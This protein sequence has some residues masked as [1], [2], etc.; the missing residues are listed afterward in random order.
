MPPTEEGPRL[1]AK[2]LR[3]RIT[4]PKSQS[5]YLSDA[6]RIAKE[7]PGY[8]V[9]GSG[10]NVT[11]AVDVPLPLEDVQLWE[12][13]RQLAKIVQ[14]WKRSE[15]VI[16]GGPFDSLL[17]LEQAVSAVR[18]C[19][20]ARE[21]SALGDMFCLG[22]EAPDDDPTCF[23]CRLLEGVSRTGSYYYE[24]LGWHQFGRLSEDLSSFSVDKKEIVRVCK[25]RTGDG[26]CTSCPAFSWRRVEDEINELPDMIRLGDD[27]PYEVKYSEIDATQPLGIRPRAQSSRW[28]TAIGQNGGGGEG[29]EGELVRNVPSVR[30]S[31]IAAQ[32]S[33]MEEIKNVVQLPLT[34]PDYFE[35]IGVEP[36]R[37][38]LLYGPPG[39]GK[40]LIGQAVATES[41]AHLEII[42][43]PE[44]VS[45]WVG[46]SA[47]NLRGIFER[48][49][50][51]EPS[52]ILVD[53]IDA[54]APKRDVASHQHDVQ[55]VS[56]LLVLLDGLEVRGRVVVIGAT[57]RIDSVDPAVRR[58]GRFDYH[59]EV[60]QPDESG[61]EAILRVHVMKMK[62]GGD[63]E[64]AKVA[65]QTDGFSGAELAALC[66]EAGLA[67]IHRGLSR[68]IGPG[69]LLVTYVDI[70]AGLEAIKR[71]RM[72]LGD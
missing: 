62:T 29:S 36:H 39:N 17:K 61:R 4:F 49:R 12:R 66:R 55:L 24:H 53:E 21:K 54:I 25:V 11:H 15:I 19:Y 56:Q 30:Y 22:K 28:A 46:Q 14:Y 38:I 45:K 23:G 58:P 26:L 69:E 7:L 50:Q 33:A 35:E 8:S 60:V 43:G 9:E 40:T 52:V 59:I 41:G 51:L 71:K 57:N 65:R 6:V 63:V 2:R 47:E 42:N 18:S 64:L 72:E 32:D 5:K 27:S 44:I 67:A 37:G 16:E 70:A 68:G 34:H 1:D 20:M 13:V 10:K 48:A 31:D 3:A